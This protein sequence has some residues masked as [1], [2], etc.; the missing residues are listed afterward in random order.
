MFKRLLT[1]LTVVLIMI[2]PTSCLLFEQ[3]GGT[4]PFFKIEG[5]E[6]SNLQNV[7]NQPTL[8]TTN[9]PVLWNNFYM[10]MD[11]QKTFHAYSRNSSGSNLFALDCVQDGYMG[12]EVGLDT[13]FVVTLN[14]YNNDF[15]AN[16]TINNILETPNY[17]SGLS[18]LS[19]Y[20]QE[21]KEGIR[22]GGLSLT[23]N[24]PPSV[25]LSTHQFKIIFILKNG[26]VFEQTNEPVLLTL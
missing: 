7:G 9:S 21:N 16:D 13:I 11:F 18:P 20:V 10:S 4:L 26:E 22:Y 2:G 3:C 8:V 25:N 5:L 19:E 23:L 6:I 24:Q 14:N 12:S 17:I 15:V 1:I